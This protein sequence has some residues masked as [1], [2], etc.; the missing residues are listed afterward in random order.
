ML[1][2]MV[3]YVI[4][5]PVTADTAPPTNIQLLRHPMDGRSAVP[6]PTCGN[7]PCESAHRV[8]AEGGEQALERARAVR[9]RDR[10]PEREL[11]GEAL[12]VVGDCQ[13]DRQRR[14]DEVRFGGEGHAARGR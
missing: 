6:A 13:G 10:G 1:P 8:A 3:L 4:T 12:P 7:G 9:D 11:G 5:S 14:R 2:N